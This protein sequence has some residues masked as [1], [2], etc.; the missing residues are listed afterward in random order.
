M[1]SHFMAGRLGNVLYWAANSLAVI[2]LIRAYNLFFAPATVDTNNIPIAID[3]AKTCG[4]MAVSIWL[5][6]RIC[7]Y[8]V[9]RR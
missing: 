9:A 3:D 6:G 5:I 2:L 4:I 1:G 8:I 7:L